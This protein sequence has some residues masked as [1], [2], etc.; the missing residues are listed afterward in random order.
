MATLT[1]S[2]KQQ[3]FDA[4]GN[5]LAGGKLYTYA[6]GTTT[7]LATYTDSSGSTPNTNPVILDSRGE[8]NVWL[9]SAVYKFKLTTSTD[10]ELWTV[11]NIASYNYDVLTALAASGGSALVGFLQSGTSATARTVQ[12][13]LRDFVSVKDF[14][15]VGDGVTDDTAA[16]QSAATYC[17]NNSKILFVPTPASQYLITST[18]TIQSPF[19]GEC[20]SGIGPGGSIGQ[21]LAKSNITVFNIIGSR[22]NIE[23]IGVHFNLGGAATSGAVGFQ[24]GDSTTQFSNNF[25][26]QCYVRYAYNAFKSN[27]AG[28]G[29]LW[30]NTFVNCRGDFCQHYAWYFD[31]P[32]GST[33]QTWIDCMNDGEPTAATSAGWYTNNIDDVAWI[34]CQADDCYDGNAIYI[35]LAATACI[36]NFRSEGTYFRTNASQ[37]IYCNA[38]ADIGNVKLQEGTIQVGAGNRMSVVRLGS[39]SGG[40]VIG[41]I[42]IQTCTITSGTVYRADTNGLQFGT[43]NVVITGSNIKTADVRRDDVGDRTRFAN[44]FGRIAVDTLDPT[45]GTFELG[46]QYLTAAVSSTRSTFGKLCITGGTAGTL[47]G[48]TGS[49]ASGSRYVTV[50]STSGIP[51]GG[52]ITIAGVSGVKRVVHIQDSTHLYIDTDANATVSGAAVAFS[53]PVFKQIGGAGKGITGARPTLGANDYGVTYLDTTLDADGK[54]IWWN[55]TAWVDATGAVV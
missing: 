44:K 49:V 12:S 28:S 4:N 10:V 9:G 38:I 8:A 39:S 35:N 48:V 15:A 2:A 30:N 51:E 29:T 17:K 20:A 54:P 27:S 43:G 42:V 18:V 37:L 26:R 53:A 21:F 47:S 55:G 52:Y 14:G 3:F 34:N 22:L 24:F 41:N 33:T 40:G 13:K 46:D 31:A 1:P 6:A 19:V 5:P 16:I 7:P 50:S 25:V 36:K 11:D 45:S 32:V 23:N